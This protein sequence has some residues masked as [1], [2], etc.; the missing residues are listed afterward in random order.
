[1]GATTLSLSNPEDRAA[2]ANANSPDAVLQ[3][4]IRLANDYRGVPG[5]ESRVAELDAAMDVVDT[6]SAADLDELA[7]Y[8]RAGVAR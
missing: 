5:Y 6:V 3:T 7:V 8:V 4:L 2:V 1:M